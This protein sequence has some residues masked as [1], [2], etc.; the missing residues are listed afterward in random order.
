M[1]QLFW[2]WDSKS[3]AVSKQ[4]ESMGKAQKDRKNTRRDKRAQGFSWEEGRT[5]LSLPHTIL[6]TSH[7]LLGRWGYILF[8]WS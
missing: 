3:L 5:R 2:Q 7:S 1:F 6:L 4:I 8:T